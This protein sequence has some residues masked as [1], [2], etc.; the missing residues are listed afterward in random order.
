M[1]LDYKKYTS[2]LTIKPCPEMPKP[3]RDT[4]TDPTIWTALGFANI[5][6]KQGYVIGC[7]AKA[8]EVRKVLGI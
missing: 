5:A 1:A 8:L 4:E 3:P 2:K 7:E 6:F